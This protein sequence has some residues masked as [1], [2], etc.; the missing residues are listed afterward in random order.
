MEA[1]EYAKHIVTDLYL[2]SYEKAKSD[3]AR[4]H[5]KKVSEQKEE[6]RNYDTEISKLRRYYNKIL[7]MLNTM[8]INDTNMFNG[9]PFYS[10]ENVTIKLTDSLSR[11]KLG[12]FP[13]CN[14]ITIIVT[15]EWFSPSMITMES[16]NCAIETYCKVVK[17]EHITIS[18]VI[19]G[20]PIFNVYTNK[21]IVNLFFSIGEELEK[22][23]YT[24][25]FCGE[26]VKCGTFDT[27]YVG[28][29]NSK[30]QVIEINKKFDPQYFDIVKDNFQS[31]LSKL[32]K[33]KSIKD[34]E[35]EE[36]KNLYED[37]TKKLEDTKV[38]YDE[39][40][41]DIDTNGLTYLPYLFVSHSYRGIV[42]LNGK[43][44]AEECGCGLSVDDKFIGSKEFVCGRQETICYNIRT[45]MYLW[46]GSSF[47]VSL[48]AS[49]HYFEVAVV[50]MLGNPVDFEYSWT[51]N[52]NR[53]RLLCSDDCNISI[54]AVLCYKIKQSNVEQVEIMVKFCGKMKSILRI[55]NHAKS[56]L[57]NRALS[58]LDRKCTILEK[59][60]GVPLSEDKYVHIYKK[61]YYY[62][63][64]GMYNTVYEVAEVID[65]KSTVVAK[66]ESNNCGEEKYLNWL[67]KIFSEILPECDV[68]IDEDMV[69]YVRASA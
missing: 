11:F 35:I 30:T 39:V 69:T 37:D 27:E 64:A 19:G 12:N 38:V 31:E 66:Y 2:L 41:G 50:D 21:Y 63:C 59:N 4:Y 28:V 45:G 48:L 47:V 34:K 9:R 7:S 1:V 68:Y 65:R 53:N 43:K 42:L 6:Q 61:R 5:L 13:N 40:I 10:D 46:K 24:I 14:N 32:E 55:S 15:A 20:D 29:D 8:Q 54:N 56:N 23:R 58:G 62:N 57:L 52:M 17:S 26:P 51:L 49:P 25:K 67:R 44:Y 33:K 22:M 60:M 18:E 3:L 16:K 36:L